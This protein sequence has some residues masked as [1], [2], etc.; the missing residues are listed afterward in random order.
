M[1]TQTASYDSDDDDCRLPADTL[2]V[3]Q[4]FLKEKELREQAEQ[5]REKTG[6]DFEEDWQLSQFWYNTSTKE[7]LASVVRH[8]RKSLGD[9]LRVA[10]LSAPSLYQHV[11][12]VA[13]NG[14]WKELFYFQMCCVF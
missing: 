5:S 10:L 2:A 8:F 12:A 14:K 7:K 3:L 6:T 4:E 1:S 11:K 13:D 9:G